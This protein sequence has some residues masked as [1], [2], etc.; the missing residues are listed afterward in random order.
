MGLNTSH[1]AWDGSYSCFNTFRY[2]AASRIN[3]NLD[4]YFGY[5]PMGTKSLDDIDHPLRYLFDH[6]DCD[7]EL[8][9]SECTMIAF[10]L[11]Q[12]MNAIAL[13]DIIDNVLLCGRSNYRMQEFYQDCEK[14]KNGCMLAVKKKEPLVFG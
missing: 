7:G 5:N 11:G 13:D 9:E 4:E 12:V 3:V 2:A 1:G 14:F 8:N 10:G 6:S